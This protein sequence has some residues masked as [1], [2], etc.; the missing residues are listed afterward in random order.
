MKKVLI[1]VCLFFPF[2][3]SANTFIEKV[4]NG[5]KMRVVEYDISSQKYDLK[6]L[7]SS[8]GGEEPLEKILLDNNA[9]SGV[10]GVFFCPSDYSFCAG[11]EWTTNNQRYFSGV[12]HEWYEPSW[13][14][15]M[16]VLDTEKNSFI[17]Q[18]N[19]I[20]DDKESQIYDWLSNWPLLLKDGENQLEGYY[21]MWA[22]DAKMKTSSTKNFICNSSDKKK[23]YFGLVYAIDI[24]SLATL[25][26]SFWCS[27]ALNLDAWLS[28]AL[29][30]NGK[31]IVWPQRDVI[32]GIG[33]VPKFD[34][35]P[36]EEK[37]QKV[38]QYLFQRSQKKSKGN[39]ELQKKLLKNYITQFDALK[40]K[41]YDT[42]SVDIVEQNFVWI[43]EKVGYK[44]DVTSEKYLKIIYLI[45]K[46]NYNL[47]F[48]IVEL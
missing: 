38:V 8:N 34:L 12:N 9:I 15:P 10:N 29:V 33:V 32:D 46:I 4:H 16:F 14:K 47:K 13:D 20:N 28:T 39:I 6:F 17:Y 3:A 48:K 24:D 36:L 1:I 2:L 21:D 22:I 31:F 43:E 5:Y 25:L 37:S 30:Y 19:N 45:N 7:K 26:K 18:R 35:K 11:K 40:T 27:D 41:I 23:I 44:V 42:Y